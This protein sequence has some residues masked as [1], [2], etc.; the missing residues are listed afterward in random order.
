MQA[1]YW[2]KCL[3][4]RSKLPDMSGT[5]RT[6]SMPEMVVL[7]MT[8]YGVVYSSPAGARRLDGGCTYWL[9]ALIIAVWCWVHCT[10]N[11]QHLPITKSGLKTIPLEVSTFNFIKPLLSSVANKWQAVN[12]VDKFLTDHCP[13][14]SPRHFQCVNTK[15]WHY[16]QS[17]YSRTG[18]PYY[19]KPT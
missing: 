5:L 16:L 10:P 8:S 1:S 15:I 17:S 19:Q 7:A 2:S 12:S 18:L 3:S 6:L 9:P 11:Y 4:N 14:A 13:I